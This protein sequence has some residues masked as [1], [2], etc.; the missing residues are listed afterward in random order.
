MP[1]NVGD[2]CGD[3]GDTRQRQK[4]EEDFRD[5]ARWFGAEE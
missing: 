4:P 1:K 5:T 2:S 3:G